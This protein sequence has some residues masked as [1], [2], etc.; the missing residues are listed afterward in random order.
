[1]VQFCS[2]LPPCRKG[3]LLAGRLRFPNTQAMVG[4]YSAVL[5]PRRP[6]LW[7]GSGSAREQVEATILNHLFSRTNPSKTSHQSQRWSPMGPICAALLFTAH[8]IMVVFSAL[9]APDTFRLEMGSHLFLSC[10][11]PHLKWRLHEP[12]MWSVLCHFPQTWTSKLEARHR[13]H[14]FPPS[15]PEPSMPT[16]SIE[17]LPALKTSSRQ[18]RTSTAFRLIK[19]SRHTV[20]HEPAAKG[21]ETT[22]LGPTERR[23]KEK[24]RRGDGHL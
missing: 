3:N 8:A 18:L 15:L 7:V 11:H 12:V 1:M 17:L 2:H 14:K 16:R 6:S 9:M 10:P 24:A 4:K 13:P 21:A 19:I 23:G 20:S 22:A 5:L